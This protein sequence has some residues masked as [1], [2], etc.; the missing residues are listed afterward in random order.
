MKELLEFQ[1]HQVEIRRRRYQSRLGVSVYPNGRITVATNKTLS[2]KA[3]LKF[4]L[5]KQ[6]WIQKCLDEA[7]SFREKYPPKRFI[8]GE[9]YPYL[10]KSYSLKILQFAKPR[11]EFKDNDLIFYGPKAPDELTVQDRKTYFEILKKS[12]IK[13]AKKLMTQRVEHYSEKMQL[14]PTGLSFRRQKTLW[15]GGSPE[16]RISLNCKLI[17]APLGVIDYVVVHELSH[18]RHKNHS[19]RFWALVE[20]HVDTREMSRHW[21]RENLYQSDFLSTQSELW[22]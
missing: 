21:L 20:K 14:F 11:I 3:I 9:E 8:P 2:Q 6:T 5:E 12:Y 15:G 18:I 7:Q 13:V 19:K 10:G 22:L 4:L 16:D 17:I 1:G